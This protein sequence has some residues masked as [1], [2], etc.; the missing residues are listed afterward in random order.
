MVV[1]AQI[2]KVLCLKIRHDCMLDEEV[3][4]CRSVMP[5][6]DQVLFETFHNFLCSPCLTMQSLG[7]ME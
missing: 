6:T 7:S 3:A 4:D 2:P 5:T 1:E